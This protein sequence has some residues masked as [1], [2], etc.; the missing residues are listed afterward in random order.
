MRSGGRAR[1]A[2][3]ATGWLAN[4][5][6]REGQQGEPRTR[7]VTG[8]WRGTLGGEVHPT[9]HRV[10]ARSADALSGAAALL[11]GGWAILT[12]AQADCG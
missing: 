8:C 4:T 6:G 9:P 12:A 7:G 3:C 5:L 11:A 2:A 10:A 1:D